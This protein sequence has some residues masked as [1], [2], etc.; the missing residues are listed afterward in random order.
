MGLLRKPAV[1]F[2]RHPLRPSPHIRLVARRQKR[3]RIHSRQVHSEGQ[4]KENE[5]FFFGDQRSSLCLVYSLYS[6]VT[7]QPCYLQVKA[8]LSKSSSSFLSQTSPE[9]QQKSPCL[10]N[11]TLHDGLLIR[12]SSREMADNSSLVFVLDDRISSSE[13]S[14]AELK[15]HAF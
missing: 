11:C 15:K 12:D 14:P 1:V 3:F 9:P 10:S 4:P 5:A 2:T 8:L 13:L 7:Q 6:G